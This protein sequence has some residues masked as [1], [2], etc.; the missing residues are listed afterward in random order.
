MYNSAHM[1]VMK[2]D[3]IFCFSVFCFLFLFL[4]FYNFNSLVPVPFSKKNSNTRVE[5]INVHTTLHCQTC[6]LI[7]S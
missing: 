5:L 1:N 4:F 7:R 2:S 3:M 6:N